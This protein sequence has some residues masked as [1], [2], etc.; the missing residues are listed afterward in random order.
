VAKVFFCCVRIKKKNAANSSGSLS[1]PIKGQNRDL[2]VVNWII[3]VM[4][5][6]DTLDHPDKELLEQH[7]VGFDNMKN[8]FDD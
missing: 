7:C 2:V 3:D 6:L 5:A 1:A 8:S 4:T